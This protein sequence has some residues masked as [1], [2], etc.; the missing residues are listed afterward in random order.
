MYI[1]EL[2]IVKL[3]SYIAQRD[4]SLILDNN[5]SEQVAFDRDTLDVHKLRAKLELV[6]DES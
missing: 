6:V 5:R 3:K 1:L 4:L 2:S